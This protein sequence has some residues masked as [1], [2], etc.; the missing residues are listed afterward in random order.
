MAFK[1]G[2]DSFH[3]LIVWFVDGNTRT[4]YSI[5]WR[6]R[7]SKTRDP[8]IGFE[9]FYKRIRIWGERAQVVEIYEN[10][11]GTKNGRKVERFENGIKVELKNN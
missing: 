3:K 4:R 7:F 8:K 9:R 6:H 1:M 5:D 11:Y 10:I 2:P